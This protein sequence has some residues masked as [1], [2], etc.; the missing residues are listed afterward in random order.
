MKSLRIFLLLSVAALAACA[1]RKAP[2]PP[3]PPPPVA[4]PQP[5]PVPPPPPPPAADWRDLALTPGSWS[6]RGEGAVSTATFAG[7][8][9]S[10]MLRCD[11]NA[12]QVTLSRPGAASGNMMTIRTSSISRNLPLA[13]QGE[14]AVRFASLPSNDRFLDAIA[15]S[16]GR[17]TVEVPGAP[18]LVIPA[19]P[20]PA[21][22]V[23]DCRF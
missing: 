15:F 21:R 2:T 18:M 1:P 19:W 5:R 16:R 3:P 10:F 7:A 23:E 13:V 8:G 4:T 14:P 11:R 6:Y 17:F 22:V 9:G 12:R 20:E